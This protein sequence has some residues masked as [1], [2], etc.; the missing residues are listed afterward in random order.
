LTGLVREVIGAVESFEERHGPR[1]RERPAVHQERFEAT[2][3][4]VIC[5]ALFRYS[6]DD[7]R[8]IAVPF[9]KR[10]L[11]AR[12]RYKSAVLTEVFPTVVRQL[13][14]PELG[15]IEL[16]V[17]HGHVVS[18]DDQLTYHNTP[19]ILLAGSAL[20]EM[21]DVLSLEA[22]HFGRSDD[23]ETI[24]LKG[25][26]PHPTVDGEWLEYEDNAETVSYREQ[27]S[28]I[29]RWLADAEIDFDPTV[30]EMVNV[31][32]RR[33]RRVFNNG[34]FREG[35]RLW[36]AFWL[37]LSKAKRKAGITIEGHP[38]A[39]L[40]YGQ[41]GL[42]LLYGLVGALPPEGDLYD[43]PG[44]PS[45]EG[46]KKIVNAAI[47]SPKG[48]HRMPVNTRKYFPEEWKYGH[49]LSAIQ[50]H[51]APIAGELF[52]GR[53]MEV[54]FLESQVLIG[55]L[56]EAKARDAV[57]LPIHDGVLAAQSDTVEIKEVMKRVFH[58]Q[59]GLEASVGIKE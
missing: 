55:V 3:E 42:R 31:N 38:I 53:G 56:L 21:A 47:S 46:V 22:H 12:S 43:V 36:G 51:H 4:A 35:G 7:T 9:S 59:T 5:D 10:V 6:Q 19:T 27:L 49:I 13:A 34:S 45:R 40:D 17:G 25:P 32:E 57:V 26:K 33:L 52:S 54:Q 23:E 50:S 11:G 28:N 16:V 8:P 30:D 58:Q 18:F 24:I 48:Q 29:N 2:I 14:S 1:K 41:M 20:K 44:L 39:E 15:F 37:N